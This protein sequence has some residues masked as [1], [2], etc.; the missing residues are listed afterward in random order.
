MGLGCELQVLTTHGRDFLEEGEY[1][2]RVKRH[3]LE[4]YNFLAVSAIRGR[5]DPKLW[6][7]HK[8]KL[9]ET[10]GFSRARLAGAIA[11]RLCKAVLNPYETISKLGQTGSSQEANP[12]ASFVR[13]G[14]T[15]KIERM[16]ETTAV[17]N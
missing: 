17:R 8:R 12:S 2:A 10:V 16:C 14:S 15:A 11:I 9:S 1:A 13:T 7:F 5:R 3:L 6:N 4:Y